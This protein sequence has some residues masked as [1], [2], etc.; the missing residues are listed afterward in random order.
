MKLKINKLFII[1]FL[2]LTFFI[3]NGKTSYAYDYNSFGFKLDGTDEISF[4]RSTMELTVNGKVYNISFD[5][6]EDYTNFSIVR[7]NAAAA[8]NYGVLFLP[9]SA[10]KLTLSGYSSNIKNYDNNAIF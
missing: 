7:E 3:F 10:E 9:S 6:P 1:L 4:N 8:N 2:F 5:L